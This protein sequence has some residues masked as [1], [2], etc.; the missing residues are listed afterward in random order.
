MYILPVLVVF[1][2]FFKDYFPQSQKM[3][4]KPMRLFFTQ[5]FW[6]KDASVIPGSVGIVFLYR[7]GR[8][9]WNFCLC[10][11]AFDAIIYSW[12]EDEIFQAIFMKILSFPLY[13]LRKKD[14]WAWL[15]CSSCKM[16]QVPFFYEIIVSQCI[17][18]LTFKLQNV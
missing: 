17:L 11:K 7:P 10:A 12:F 4:T 16:L 1:R 9:V 18:L 15:N 13:F 8:I 3:S 2:W 6:L 14:S 5:I